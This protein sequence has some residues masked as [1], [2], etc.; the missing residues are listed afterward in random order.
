[1]IDGRPSITVSGQKEGDRS[2][3]AQKTRQAAFGSNN[4][5]IHLD[6]LY[7]ISGGGFRGG[8]L[9]GRYYR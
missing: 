9:L 7:G 3:A 1:M 2:R 8:T 4:A 6:S 5:H